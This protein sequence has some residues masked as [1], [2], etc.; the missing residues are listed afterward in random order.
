MIVFGKAKKFYHRIV[1][2]G[3]TIIGKQTNLDMRW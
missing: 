3:K 2:H 1:D